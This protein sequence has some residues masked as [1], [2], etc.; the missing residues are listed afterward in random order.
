MQEIIN[1]TRLIDSNGRHIHKLRLQI[2]DACNFRCFYCMPVQAKFL[3]HPSLLS[4]NEI[5]HI[6]KHLVSCGIDDI[7]VSGGEPLLRADFD[8]IITGLS[9]LALKRLGLTTNGYRLGQ[10]VDFLKASRCRHINVSLDTL[11]A[12]K[13]QEITKFSNFE[14]V[15]RAILQAKER[16]LYVKTNTVIMR[17]I[18]DGEIFDFIEFSAKYGI[19]VR[20]LELM[21]IGCAKDDH[22][23]HFITAK[24]IIE[25][26]EQRYKLL[27][28][29]VNIDS[30][31]FNFTT[32]HGAKIGFI[33]SESQS[34][35][36]FCSRLRL[37]ADGY[38]RACLMSKAGVSLKK[39]PKEVYPG[40]IRKVIELK[41]TDRIRQIDQ[42]MYQIGG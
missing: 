8:E 20:F 30:T 28:Q 3:P 21:K 2:T 17:G 15:C 4:S 13:F 26:I 38:L 1:K 41:P 19:E 14:R 29:S 35:C 18:N 7:R 16:G 6:C 5:L 9:R 42:P 37:S 33:A 34:F 24:E 32:D 36:N 11:N 10:K 12:S 27:P 23:H 31:A 39:E 25:K 22:E 40:L